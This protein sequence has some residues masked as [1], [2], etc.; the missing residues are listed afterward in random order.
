MNKNTGYQT[1]KFILKGCLKNCII[2]ILFF[3][4]MASSQ[5]TLAQCAMCKATAESNMKEHTNNFGAGLNK[6]ILYLLAM[7]YILGGVGIFIWYRHRKQYN[8]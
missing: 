3:T 7:P 2:L 6:G 8:S 5:Q 4:M 1:L